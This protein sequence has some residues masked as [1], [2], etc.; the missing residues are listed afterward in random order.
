MVMMIAIWTVD[1]A[2]FFVCVLFVCHGVPVD[3]LGAN[4]GYNNS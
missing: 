3:I 4:G 1:M 2:F